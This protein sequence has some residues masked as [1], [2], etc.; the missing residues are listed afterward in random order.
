MCA[1]D[2]CLI[3]EPGLAPFPLRVPILQQLNS[4]R[5]PRRPLW[6]P[7]RGVINA[8]RI[9]KNNHWTQSF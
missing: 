2:G 8:V 9:V 4:A 7:G 3:N 6:V 5:D 1:Q